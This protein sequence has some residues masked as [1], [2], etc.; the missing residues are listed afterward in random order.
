[1]KK[2]I[3]FL[4]YTLYTIGLFGQSDSLIFKTIVDT[5]KNK[6]LKLQYLDFLIKINIK[7][8]SVF[9]NYSKKYIQ[10]A[11]TLGYYDKA[12]EKG[13]R[14]FYSIN[15][16]QNKQK[17]A[18]QLIEHLQQYEKQ[19]KDSFLIGNLYL[20][21]GGAYFGVNFEK[22]IKNYTKA[23]EQFGKK[24]S[25]YIAD[26]YLFN[27][28]AKGYMGR[29]VEAIKDYE[30]AATYYENLN[31]INFVNNAKIGISVIYSM[32]G[33]Y[34]NAKK[35]RDEIIDY[36][37]K[38]KTYDAIVVS[39]SNQA[40]DYKEQNLLDKQEGVLL[41]ALKINTQNNASE[42]FKDIGIN[43]SL[44]ILY[45]KKENKI[46]A[47]KH[48]DNI[49]KRKKDFNNN[50]EI[51]YLYLEALSN[52]QRLLGLNN[53]ALSN[54]A[55]V[56]DIVT[57][58][59]NKDAEIEVKKQLAILYEI[60]NQPEKS[61]RIYKEHIR[62]KDSIFNISKTNTLL[63]Y[64]TLYETERREKELIKKETSIQ[65]LKKD[66]QV[67]NRVL[68][69]VIVGLSLLFTIIYLYRNR[70]YLTK[71]NK[72]QEDYTHQLLSYQ[73]GER[74]RISKDLH[75]GLGQSL[76]LIKNKIVLSEDENTK[77]M[78]NNAIEEVRTI[79]KALHPFQLEELG[80]IKAIESIVS[81]LDE[82]TTIFI[83]SKI[84][85]IENL[86]SPRKEV[87]IFRIVQE[88]LNNIIKHSSAKAAKIEI[89]K[90]KNHIH[91]TIKDNGKGFDFSEKYSDF[92]SLG[93]KTLKERS[94]F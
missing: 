2:R 15:I 20:K 9:V 14:F 57:K 22:A 62:L 10:L 42:L 26:A 49:E 76:L 77:N 19:V 25:I 32:N 24:D 31:D 47:K 28:Q 63:Y 8:T 71:A 85:A 53:F 58:I 92:S 35:V 56:N 50:P 87:N 21:K 73:E 48:L 43:A 38:N 39:L 36:S 16:L 37:S 72:L 6:E 52:Y 65:L 88:S 75:D 80:L 46:A 44:V 59:K 78:V 54:M 68:V 13:N 64:E 1:L 33:F 7:N 23:I 79:S 55:K 51:K 61:Y 5:T 45:S 18:L 93:L 82:Y 70:L 67:K 41:K 69:L 30:I 94:K 29:F 89:D 12:I 66:S 4:L 11:E 60:N 3:L 40:I 84:D 90:L 17:E 86:F 81:Q 34:D 83:S 91:I 27:G 74:K